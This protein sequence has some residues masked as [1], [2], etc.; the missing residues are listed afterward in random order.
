MTRCRRRTLV[1]I[2]AA[3]TLAIACGDDGPGGPTGPISGT[4]ALNLTT[5]NADDAALVLRLTGPG[6]TQVSAS[7]PST[8][9]YSSQDGATLTAVIVGDL[10][11]G[12][13]LRFRVPDVNA[14]SSHSGT[15][16]EVADEANA[17]R[18]SLAGYGLS[19]TAGSE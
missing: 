2:A 7:D 9:L 5:P 15:V 18:G 14:V 4:L 1:A 10:Q 6:I 16:L 19:V 12:S 3:L 17:L 11:N 13:V 8:Y